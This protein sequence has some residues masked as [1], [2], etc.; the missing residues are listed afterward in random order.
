MRAVSVSR[1]GGL[2]AL[3]VIR[4]EVPQ[5]RN[6]EVLLR[7][8]A[9]GINPLDWKLRGGDAFRDHFGVP[10]FV[11]GWDVSGEVVETGGRVTEFEPG[12]AVFGLL[13][14]PAPAGGYAEYV[15]APARELV[16]KPDALDHHSAAALP[17]AGLA[18]WQALFGEGRL[19]TGQRVL[20]HGAA[21][22]VGHLAVQLAKRHGATVV[23]SASGRNLEYL[24]GLGADETIDYTVDQPFA[25][26]DWVDVI[27]DAGGCRDNE[28]L[29]ASLVRWG[30]YIVLCGQRSPSPRLQYL[31]LRP[32]LRTLGSLA[33]M[34]ADGSLQLTV[35]TVPSLEGIV[36]AH[37]M[38]ES[39]HVRG[40]IVVTVR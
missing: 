10:P 33:D 25:N 20:I 6:D 24:R 36:Q 2:D 23:A 18:A 29:L 17:L 27:V 9:L 8:H 30:R 5:P 26:L 15:S 19:S 11:P 32:D 1:F 12:A 21:G 40:K 35:T 38:S 13:N 3:Q 31:K 7:V 16:R 39:G 28:Q 34:A 4:R 14:F 37:T 22:G